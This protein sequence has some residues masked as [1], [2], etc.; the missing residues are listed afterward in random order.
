MMVKRLGVIWLSLA[1]VGCASWYDPQV[2]NPA[3]YHAPTKLDAQFSITGRFAITTASKSYYGNFN[4]QHQPA[5]DNLAL[6]SPLGNTVAQIQVE[7]SEAKLTTSEG[8]YSGADVDDLMLTNL[9]FTLPLAYLHYWIQG[10]PLPMYPL[11]EQLASGFTQQEWQVEYLR[12]QDPNHPQ[13]VVLTKP[14]LRIK[15]LLNWPE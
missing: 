12:W 8:S 7:S 14:P 2:T 4:W 10:V 5:Y 15:L 9:G 6:T 11:T 3:S 1:L 13:V